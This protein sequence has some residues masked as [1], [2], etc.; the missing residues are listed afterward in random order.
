[1]SKDGSGSQSRDSERKESAA[2]PWCTIPFYYRVRG[3][4]P[5]EAKAGLACGPQIVF[6][7]RVCSG[8]WNCGG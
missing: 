2:W 1:M 3:F 8:P 5:S 4:Y 6:D 7:A